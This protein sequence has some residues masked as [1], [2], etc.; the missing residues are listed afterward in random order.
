V[1]R[2][3]QGGRSEASVDTSALDAAARRVLALHGHDPVR[4]TALVRDL[5][6]LRDEADR[7]AF[8]D[9]S[10]DALR[11]YRRAAREVAE[12]ERAVALARSA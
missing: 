3:R 1:V 6:R 10:P 9:P 2:P 12:A 4:L 11:A 7:Q 8:E 5:Q